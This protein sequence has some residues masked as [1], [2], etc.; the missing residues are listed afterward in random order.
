MQDQGA[1]T[2]P[3]PGLRRKGSTRSNEYTSIIPAGSDSPPEVESDYS[4]E[5]SDDEFSPAP[6]RKKNDFTIPRWATTPELLK[7]LEQQ[8]RV[9]PDRIFGRVKPL[10]VN[11]I[12]NR[13]DSGESRRRPRNSSM[14]WHG[15][16]AL[17]ADDELAYIRNMGFDP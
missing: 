11:E 1:L 15:S 10:R 14:I 6:K 2:T 16:D 5:Y 3:Q 17:T 9:N 12:F 4:D 7:R 8:A 13:R